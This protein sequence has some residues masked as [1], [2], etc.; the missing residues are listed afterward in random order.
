MY[1]DD[2]TGRVAEHVLGDAAEDETADAA[3]PMSSHH[4]E[5]RRVRTRGVEDDVT[6]PAQSDEHL[7]RRSSSLS[8]GGIDHLLFQASD[9]LLVRKQDVETHVSRP[10]GPRI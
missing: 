6:D 3:A 2:R 1:G 8:A 7:G 9:L 10:R 5:L 4:D